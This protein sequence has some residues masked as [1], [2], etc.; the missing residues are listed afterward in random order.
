MAN[1][2]LLLAFT[3]CSIALVACAAPTASLAT[4]Q[5]MR[6]AAWAA[7][8]PSTTSHNRA[9]WDFPEVRQVRGIEVSSQ[10]GKDAAPGCLG[11]PPPA[12]ATIAAAQVY[13][14]VRAERRAMTPIPQNRT[15]SPTGP[16]AI[17]DPFMYQALFLLDANGKVVAR[18][19]FCVIY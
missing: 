9:Y 13:W 1:R 18:K 7:L 4:E 5:Q 17:P 2:L 11:P 8:N 19:L 10:F 15:L 16:P 3:F 6:D 12:N 14:F